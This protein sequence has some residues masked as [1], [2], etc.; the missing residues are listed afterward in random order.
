MAKTF[1][2]VLKGGTLVN[3]DGEGLCDL[4]IRG[5]GSRRLARLMPPLPEP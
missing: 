4:G 3:Q 1:D 2:M 5:G